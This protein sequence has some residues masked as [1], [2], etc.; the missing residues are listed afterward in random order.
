MRVV[1]EP[2]HLGI[3]GS[4][5]LAC[6]RQPRDNSW[7]AHQSYLLAFCYRSHCALSLCLPVDKVSLSKERSTQRGRAEDR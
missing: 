5:L 1:L 2:G 4:A 7:R 3:S 6:F